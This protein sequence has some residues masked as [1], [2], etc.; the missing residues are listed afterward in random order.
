MS[1]FNRSV[2]W[3]GAEPNTANATV[4]LIE[5]NQLGDERYLLPW[6]MS[7]RGADSGGALYSRAMPE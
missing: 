6:Q 1:W 4:L 5:R 7:L 3:F 2:E